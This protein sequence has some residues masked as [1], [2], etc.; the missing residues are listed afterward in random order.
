M[1]P[2]FD[3]LNVIHG[4]FGA[5]WA[6]AAFLNFI[7]KPQDKS[8]YIKMS[9][10]FRISSIV[11]I[12]TGIIIFAYIYLAPYNG[13]LFLVAAALR[14]SLD[15]RLRAFLNLVGGALGLLAFGSG[16]VINNRIK[17]MMNLK[18]GDITLLE[19]RKSVSNLSAIS[20]IFLLACM[21]MML[22]AGSIAQSVFM[23]L[24]IN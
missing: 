13:S 4:F 16:I 19:L 10:F 24:Y 11:T 23:N 9:K 22:L 12:I 8:Q 21:L 1:N 2:V 20:L 18:E 3:V 6:G 5:L 14:E 17:L 15:V 7:I